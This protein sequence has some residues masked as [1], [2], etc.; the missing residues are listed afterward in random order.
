MSTRGTGLEPGE[1]ELTRDGRTSPARPARP[2]LRAAKAAVAALIVTVLMSSVLPRLAGASWGV[3]LEALR[4]VPFAWLG[5]LALIWAGGLA[6]NSFVLTGAMPGLTMRRALT[7]SLTGSAIANLLP[8]GGAAGVALN[9]Q[10]ARSWG[11]SRRAIATYTVV[12]NIWDVAAKLILPVILVPA[13][14]WG[15]DTA[16]ATWHLRSLIPV[17][18]LA[19]LLGVAGIIGANAGATAW[20]ASR[21]DRSLSAACGLMRRPREVRWGRHLVDLR[22]DCAG[23][24]RRR[25]LQMTLAVV[26]YTASLAL[27]LWGC[28]QVAGV[29]LPPH[30]I[31]V[32]FVGER[33]LSMAGLT[34]GGAGIV[35]VGLSG[36]LIAG[37]GVPLAVVTAVLLYR[38]FTYGL[39]IPVGGLGVAAWQSQRRRRLVGTA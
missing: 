9:Y 11:F 3:V 24:V 23:V 2:A 34:P 12:T 5:G 35:E 6:L 31:L 29:G 4:S 8:I 10:M 14:I 30:A 22:A 28:C 25:W 16:Y 39:E 37:G 15:G 17:G 27:L 19:V 36:L 33:L 1:Q 26:A 38:L 18:V 7:L 13:L 20:F 21:L 32:G